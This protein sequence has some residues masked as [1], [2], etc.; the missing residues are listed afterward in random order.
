MGKTLLYGIIIGLP[1]V[2]IAGPVFSRALRGINAPLLKTFQASNLPQEKLPSL[3]NSIISSLL[4]VILLGITT[5]SLRYITDDGLLKTILTFISDP[6]MVM[7]ISL[8][9]AT[10]TLGVA[11][12]TSMRKTMDIYGDAVK[13]IAMLLLIM[14]GAGALKQILIES[15][16]SLEIASGLNGLDIH[17]LIL[18]WFI[19][20]IIRVCVGSATVAGLTAAGII[21]PLIGQPGVDPNLMVLAIGA[22]SLM[23]SHVN[24]AG[25]WLFKEY[26]NLGIKDTIRSWS[27]METIVGVVGLAGVMIMNT[28]ISNT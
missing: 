21:M 12:G 23:F 22:G 14:S 19:A 28:L 15:G 11:M 13:D 1:T 24:D 10:F 7:L 20:C 6:A 27:L 4:P 9:V 25:F 18:G 2:I 5:I 8:T 3:A 16:V 17:P 26:F